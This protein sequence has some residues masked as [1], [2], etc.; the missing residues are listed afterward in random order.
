MEHSHD[1]IRRIARKITHE[2]SITDLQIM[3]VARAQGCKIPAR[4]RA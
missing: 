4:R 1:T 3:T 2:P